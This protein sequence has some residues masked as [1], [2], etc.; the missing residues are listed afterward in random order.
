[1]TDFSACSGDLVSA[2]FFVVLELR[3]DGRA[4]KILEFLRLRGICFHLLS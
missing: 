3:E 2:F 1:M 4:G